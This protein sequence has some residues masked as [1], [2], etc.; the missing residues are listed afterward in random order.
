MRS[1]LE[2][3]TEQIMSTVLRASLV[4]S[5]LGLC[6][7]DRRRRACLPDV[8]PVAGRRRARPRTAAS[9]RCTASSGFRSTPARSRTPIG[10]L[11]DHGE[12]PTVLTDR[13][14]EPRDPLAGGNR[15]RA[16]YHSD[17]RGSGRRC[18]GRVLAPSWVAGAFASRRRAE[19]SETW[20]RDRRGPCRAWPSRGRSRERACTHAGTSRRSGSPGRPIT[21]TPSST[22]AFLRLGVGR[23]G[24]RR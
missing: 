1:V 18:H 13:T 6:S 7:S 15:V 12:G 14:R 17:R 24:E 9:R 4:R 2:P 16:R 22:L 21:R 23:T 20:K 5:V 8:P 3:P 19:T 10:K 11:V